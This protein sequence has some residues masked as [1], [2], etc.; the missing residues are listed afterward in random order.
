MSSTTT[1]EIGF[2]PPKWVTDNLVTG[3]KLADIADIL[4]RDTPEFQDAQDVLWQLVDVLPPAGA[5]R[6]FIGVFRV[7]PPRAECEVEAEVVVTA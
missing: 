4:K 1:C 5:E 3:E 2:I 7:Y 6:P